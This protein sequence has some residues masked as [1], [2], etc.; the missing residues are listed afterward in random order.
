[1]SWYHPQT[2]SPFHRAICGLYLAPAVLLAGCGDI[3]YEIGRPFDES[4]VEKSLVVGQSS[5]DDVL[6]LLRQPDGVGRYHSPLEQAP[7]VM[8]SYNVERG[9]FPKFT[10]RKMLFVF[11]RDEK[12][13]GYIWFAGALRPQSE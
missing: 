8:W 4:T 10:R 3:Q 7:L 2:K 1:M 13:D 6:A 12:Y 5:H 9:S 11:F